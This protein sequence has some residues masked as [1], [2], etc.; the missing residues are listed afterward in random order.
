MTGPCVI[1]RALRPMARERTMVAAFLN[2]EMP[3]PHP[4]ERY[5]E[6]FQAAFEI[7][8]SIKTYGDTCHILTSVNKE[9]NDDILFGA[10]GKFTEIDEAMPWFDL[11]NLSEASDSQRKEIVIPEQL[12]PNFQS[13]FFGFIIRKH[14][15][16]FEKSGTNTAFSVPQVRKFLETLF[17]DELIS[18]NFG[19][20][21]VS[22]VQQ[23]QGIDE[24]FSLPHLRKLRIEIAR[25]NPPDDFGDYEKEIEERLREQNVSKQNIDLEANAGQS[26]KPSEET[27]KLAHL[28]LSHGR[29]IGQG[30]NK[31]NASVTVTS[32]DHPKISLHRYDPDARSE[33]SAFRTIVEEERDN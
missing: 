23:R 31:D 19:T 21:N 18:Q 26:I 13:A 22:I 32:E 29:V 11:N 20:I 14:V 15:F 2:I 4:P 30:K 16:V 6:L 27:K 8:K 10:I 1:E 24:I 25:P 17:S 5:V 9:T 28:A 3:A 12:R 33:I 7:K